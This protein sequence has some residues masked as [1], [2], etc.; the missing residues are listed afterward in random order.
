[1]AK[2]ELSG[3]QRLTTSFRALLL[4]ERALERCRCHPVGRALALAAVRSELDAVGANEAAPRR[5]R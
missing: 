4:A 1:M 5:E 2:R 3:R